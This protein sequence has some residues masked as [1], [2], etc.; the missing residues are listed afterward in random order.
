[1]AAAK[2]Y[3]LIEKM[4]ATLSGETVKRKANLNGMDCYLVRV[5]PP[6]DRVRAGGE[7]IDLGG[8]KFNWVG[9]PRSRTLSKGYV[10]RTVNADPLQLE[11]WMSYNPRR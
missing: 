10:G 1:M 7:F 6:R 5:S 11:I 9:Q 8:K 2:T 3:K 4:T